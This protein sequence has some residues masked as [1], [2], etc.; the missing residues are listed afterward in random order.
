MILGSGSVV[1]SLFLKLLKT[2]KAKIYAYLLVISFLIINKFVFH[3]ESDRD[4]T[5]PE[6]L[7]YIFIWVRLPSQNVFA[8][9]IDLNLIGLAG[10]Q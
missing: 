10:K 2:I 8:G 6:M 5:Y 3:W 7:R 4:Q 1:F 9:N